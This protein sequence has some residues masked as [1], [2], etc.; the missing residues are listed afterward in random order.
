VP[1]KNV[2]T[3]HGVRDAEGIRAALAE[4][5]ARDVVV[6][7]GGLLGIEM[8]E[9]LVSKGARV[10]IVE[11]RPNILPL[12]DADM[13]TMVERHMAAHG[14]RI[15]TGAAV[16]AIEGEGSVSAVVCDDSRLPADM[17]ILAIGV[18][19]NAELARKAGLQLGET[20]AIRVDA[21][22]RTS[23]PDIFAAGDCAETT[24]LVTGRP[25]YMPLGATANK[26]ARVAAVNL[27]GGGDV[28]PGVLETCICR[29]FNYGIARTGLTEQGARE[30]GYETVA[31]WVPGPDREHYMPH[32]G[33]ILLKVVADA[34]T[35]RLLGV[36]AIGPGAVDK[37]VD[38]A[39]MAIRA[40]QTVDEVAQ[41]DLAYAPPY[42]PAMDNLIT[43]A[44][45]VRNKLD[46][47]LR[48]VLPAEVM[49]RLR[50]RERLVLLDVRTPEEYQAVHL[51][52]SIQIPLGVLRD[53]AAELPRDC[54]IVT[55]CDIGLRAYEASLTL[56]AAGFEEVRVMEGGMAMWPF[57]TVA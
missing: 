8:T 47:H 53:R 3:L 55:V 20:G 26:Q 23:D 50:A 15:L 6:I 24:H 40:A 10:T 11:K 19:P 5:R 32:A 30:L 43:A 22:M 9:C 36:Q 34:R 51:P 42:S 52:H 1:L 29:V 38:V 37:R 39:V 13:A 16:R 49:R 48:G 17:V 27:C 35:R 4:G 7:G 44:N 14:V 56:R 18:V 57:E 21:G 46:G 54:P 25:C 12:L 33:M 45:V 2:F 31:A 28:F 41:A